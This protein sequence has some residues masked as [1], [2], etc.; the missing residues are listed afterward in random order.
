MRIAIFGAGG[1]AGRAAVEEARRRGHEVTAVVRDPDRHR[2][3]T[4]D[5]V[6]PVAGDITDAK[7]VAAL[8]AGHDAVIAAA[9]DLGVPAGDFFPAAS[10][11][12]VAGM[13]ESG[14]GR[15][16]VVGLASGLETKDGVLLLDTPEHPQ[17]YRDFCLG[18]VAG[19]EVLRAEGGALD[20]LVLSPSGD[21]DHGG[22]RTGRYAVAPADM[23][24]RISYADLAVALLD[25]IE[26]PTRHR[27]HVGIETG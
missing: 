4:A 25:E 2:D 20:W 24:S 17:E 6:R 18:H 11:A 5:G 19:V 21:F 1:R 10:R 8:A 14:V 22:G 9:A 7:A 23:E 26:R 13:T 12:L 3:I 27:T 16:V 15:L